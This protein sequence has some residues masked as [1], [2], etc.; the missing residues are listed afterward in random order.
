MENDWLFGYPTVIL[1]SG[2]AGSGKS[3]VADKIMSLLD[4]L[5]GIWKIRAS[6]A[7]NVKSAATNYFGWDGEK[8]DKGR[9]LLQN[10]GSIGRIYN[11]DLWVESTFSDIY[12]TTF[13]IPLNVIVIDDWRFPNESEYLEKRFKVWKIRIISEKFNSLKGTP[14]E[15]DISETALDNYDGF[16]IEIVNNSTLEELD[17]LVELAFQMILKEA[18]YNG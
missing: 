11:K 13:G 9:Q 15:N 10:I 5:K 18:V 16:D 1:I 7:T 6:F 8:D 2:K 12:D 4:E 14:R 17:K 3:Y